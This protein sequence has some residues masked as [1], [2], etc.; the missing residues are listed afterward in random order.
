LLE[1]G[2]SEIA[3][4]YRDEVVVAGKASSGS[5]PSLALQARKGV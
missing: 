4:A 1:C 2:D 3:E 5:C